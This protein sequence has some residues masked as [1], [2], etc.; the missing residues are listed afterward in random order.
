MATLYEG[1]LLG[2]VAIQTVAT[3]KC[4]HCQNPG[5]QSGIRKEENLKSLSPAALQSPGKLNW[6]PEAR[7]LGD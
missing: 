6:K 7:E 4:N 5:G 2:P 1:L 3:E